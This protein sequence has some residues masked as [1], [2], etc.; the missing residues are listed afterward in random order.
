MEERRETT[1][2]VESGGTCFRF[3][4]LIT[5]KKVKPT[6]SPQL[7]Y[8]VSIHYKADFKAF[9]GVTQT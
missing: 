9:I 6:C 8:E 4:G 2:I 5:S 7:R 3:G 1:C